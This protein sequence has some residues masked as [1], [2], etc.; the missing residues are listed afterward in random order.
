M[1]TRHKVDLTNLLSATMDILVKYRV[2]EDDNKDIAYSND[3]SRVKYDK[4]NPRVE[5]EITDLSDVNEKIKYNSN[6]IKKLSKSNEQ[7]FVIRETQ[8]NE[9]QLT[10]DL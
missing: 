3:G 6:L 7:L 5:I 9:N 10:L 4:T 1:G 8:R 2:I